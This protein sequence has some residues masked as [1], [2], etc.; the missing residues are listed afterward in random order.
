MLLGQSPNLP[1]TPPAAPQQPI[2]SPPPSQPS[3]KK[4]LLIV[5]IAILALILVGTIIGLLVSFL[6][7]ESSDEKA[8]ET[9]TRESEEESED[10]DADDDGMEN[11]DESTEEGLIVHHSSFNVDNRSAAAKMITTLGYVERDRLYGAEFSYRPK[12]PETCQYYLTNYAIGRDVVDSLERWEQYTD[13]ITTTYLEAYVL[14][15]DC[16]EWQLINGDTADSNG[17]T[18]Q[19]LPVDDNPTNNDEQLDLMEGGSHSARDGER[20]PHLTIPQEDYIFLDGSTSLPSIRRADNEEDACWHAW[21]IIAYKG[22]WDMWDVKKDI[23]ENDDLHQS[24]KQGLSEL[25]PEEN[26]EGFYIY[27]WAYRYEGSDELSY[28][29]DRGF[30]NHFTSYGYRSGACAL[31]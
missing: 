22:E 8:A 2:Y 6:G 27:M 10:R 24:I 23:L 4:T 13:P 5:L 1:P 9:E 15:K 21:Y 3:S 17:E 29:I 7:G 28:Y 11:V 31:E 26:P 25:Y 20:L 19:T 14:T 12:T 30:G 16:G 18:T